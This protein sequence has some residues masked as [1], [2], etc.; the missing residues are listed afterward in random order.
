MWEC[1]TPLLGR[2]KV[3]GASRWH[4]ERMLPAH[5]RTSVVPP[6]IR[7]GTLP[8]P[9]HPF[10]PFLFSRRSPLGPRTTERKDGR[11]AR[12]PPPA[13]PPVRPYTHTLT[14]TQTIPGRGTDELRSHGGGESAPFDPPP[15]FVFGVVGPSRARIASRR[16]RHILLR[17]VASATRWH[18]SRHGAR[19]ISWFLRP[20]AHLSQRRA[21]GRE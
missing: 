17:R 14:H 5:Q 4:R 16:A 20:H 9:S 7:I 3:A 15:P 12:R 21:A 2:L 13:A 11:A 1:S 19:S 6:W 10:S 18:C 8:L